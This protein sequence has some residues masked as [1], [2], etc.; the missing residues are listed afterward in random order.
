M[1]TR[2]SLSGA[3]L[4]PATL[5]PLLLALAGC[6]KGEGYPSLARRPA[7]RV[8]VDGQAL[9]AC[10][11]CRKKNCLPPAPGHAGC[12]RA[13]GT[14]EPV[15]PTVALPPDTAPQGD[16][17]QR[18]AALLKDSEAGDRAFAEKREAGAAAIR[19]GAGAEPGS[20]RWIEASN[21]LAGL[22]TARGAQSLRLG[23][24][25]SIEISDRVAHAVEDGDPRGAPPRPAL[26][27]IAAAKARIAALLA[28]EDA[29]L[30]PLRAAIRD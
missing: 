6:N 10:P 24:V 17:D 20:E 7:E 23:D 15:A 5:A 18:L 25:E 19:A 13:G 29:A 28:G 3:L 30:A 4:L 9:A 27:A 8:G 16:L 12:D 21:A 22:E 14:A 11:N 1:R 2:L 26:L